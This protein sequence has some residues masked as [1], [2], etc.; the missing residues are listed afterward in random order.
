[1]E[2]PENVVRDLTGL[3]KAAL[4]AYRE[5]PG[6]LEGKHWFRKPRNGPKSMWPVV[7]TDE[8]VKQLGD[9]VGFE[10]EQVE[11]M[12]EVEQP[13]QV[14]AVVRQKYANPRVI[15]CDL[16]R[17]KGV[18][19]VMVF[20]RDSRNFVPGMKVPLRSDGS[21]WVAAKHPR[22]GGKW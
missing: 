5:D 19:S 1:M 16:V 9:V 14:E 15:R 13:K 6:F 20:V 22:F 8:G 17:D 3:S 2:Y 7:W 4:R 18:E 11:A 10:P 12:K 21:R